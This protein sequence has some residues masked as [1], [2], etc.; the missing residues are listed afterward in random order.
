MIYLKQQFNRMC[1]SP[2]VGL[3]SG[4]EKCKGTGKEMKKAHE[5]KSRLS[6][7]IEL[8]RVQRTGQATDALIF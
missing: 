6:K 3:L 8:D 4:P 5:A 7:Q 2:L 1:L